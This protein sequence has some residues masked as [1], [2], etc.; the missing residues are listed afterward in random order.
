MS[1][2][3]PDAFANQDII[4]LLTV[5]ELR[6]LSIEF[7][8]KAAPLYFMWHV[9]LGHFDDLIPIMLATGGP[10]PNDD[11]QHEYRMNRIPGNDRVASARKP[12]RKP[13]NN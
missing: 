10:C 8:R 12:R 6:E 11:I 3:Y 1:M 2:D 7:A 9:T 13:G 5:D 4:H